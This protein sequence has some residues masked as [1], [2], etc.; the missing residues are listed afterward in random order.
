VISLRQQDNVKAELTF[1]T[2]DTGHFQNFRWR[3]L[4]EITLT[5]AGEYELRIEAKRIA[6]NAF[7]DVRAVQLV[8]QA[9]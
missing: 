9:T 7:C 4:G 1:Q 6:K 3:H 5:D 2:L 8:R